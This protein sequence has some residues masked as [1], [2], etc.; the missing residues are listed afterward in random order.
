MPS[1]KTRNPFAGQ[2]V[3]LPPNLLPHNGFRG[4][5]GAKTSGSLGNMVDMPKIVPATD[6]DLRLCAVGAELALARAALETATDRARAAAREAAKAGVSERAISRALG[7]A[8]S[9]TLRRWLGK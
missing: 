3:T 4:V 6:V 7:V 5:G 1:Q 8:R 9:R 2:L